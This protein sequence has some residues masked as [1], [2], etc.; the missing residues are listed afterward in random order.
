MWP[1]EVD[2]EKTSATFCDWAKKNTKFKTKIMV[3]IYEMKIE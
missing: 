1:Y 3:L 2:S